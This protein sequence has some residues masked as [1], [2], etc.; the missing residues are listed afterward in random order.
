M[1]FPISAASAGPLAPGGWDSRSVSPPLR[2]GCIAQVRAAPSPPAASP[3]EPAD[4]DSEDTMP[5]GACAAGW[6]HEP[7]DWALAPN[8]AAQTPMRRD[9]MAHRIWLEN[10]PV[11]QTIVGAA[12]VWQTDPEPGKGWLMLGFPLALAAL[13][14]NR[15]IHGQSKEEETLITAFRAVQTLANRIK[16]RAPE[17][18]VESCPTLVPHSSPPPRRAAQCRLPAASFATPLEWAGV[19]IPAAQLTPAVFPLLL[20]GLQASGQG[21][22]FFTRALMDKLTYELLAHA[23]TRAE[24]TSDARTLK[25][26]KTTVRVSR[27]RGKILHDTLQSRPPRAT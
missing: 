27:E 16:Y 15:Q 4:T 12:S 3:G 18:T 1:P 2:L 9:L 23:K 13:L 6:S 22:S 26:W 10:D 20:L 14:P 11:K 8:I 17:L 19:R 24:L 7:S 25:F 5:L 21:A